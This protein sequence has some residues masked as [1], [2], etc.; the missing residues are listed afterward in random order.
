M[1]RQAPEL[2]KPKQYS[3]A[4]HEVLAH[5]SAQID[6]QYTGPR[7]SFVQRDNK[8]LEVYLL[9]AVHDTTS[10]RKS[11]Q[12]GDLEQFMLQISVWTDSH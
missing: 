4:N 6:T 11:Q 7:S 3:E 10:P 8:L 12:T 9:Y 2:F 5:Q 1:Q